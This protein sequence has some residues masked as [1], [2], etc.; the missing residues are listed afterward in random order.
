MTPKL[1]I[2]SCSGSFWGIRSSR[3]CRATPYPTCSS[4]WCHFLTLSGG[5]REV[6]F[7]SGL[8]GGMS[9]ELGPDPSGDVEGLGQF[10]LKGPLQESQPSVDLGQWVCRGRMHF[11]LPFC[12][13]QF[14]LFTVSTAESFADPIT[15]CWTLNGKQLTYLGRMQG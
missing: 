9:E 14:L 7:P 8:R 3:Y 5:W 11:D 13:G 1:C 15:Y 10:N 2:P 12:L 4:L 6:K